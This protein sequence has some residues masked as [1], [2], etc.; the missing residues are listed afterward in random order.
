MKQKCGKKQLILRLGVQVIFAL[1][2]AVLIEAAFNFRSFTQGYDY[3]DLFP[4][5]TADNGQLIISKTFEESRYIKKLLVNGK[6]QKNPYYTVRLTVI[7]E[8]GAEEM[9]ELEDRANSVFDQ[10]FTNIGYD[11]KSMEI[12]FGD[13]NLVQINGVSISNQ[14]LFSKYRII[15][16]A[17]VLLL[18]S[19]ILIERS[20]ILQHLEWLYAIAAVGFG[21]LL[22]WASGPEAITWDEEAHF[23]SVYTATLNTASVRDQAAESNFSRVPITVNTGEERILLER[24]MNTLSE[25]SKMENAIQNMETGVRQ[26]LIYFP[27]SIFM[28]LARCLKLP[29]SLQ[30]AAGRIGNMLICVLMNILAIRLA[31][32]KKVLIT[33]A[34]LLPTL[35]FQSC[36][37]T[38]DGIIFAALTLG[39]V[40]CLN[41][42]QNERWKRKTILSAFGLSLLLFLWACLAKPVYLP[43]ILFLL[44][45]L[46][47]MLSWC[48]AERKKT[49]KTIVIIIGAAGILAVAG[50][51]IWIITG[52]L[53]GNLFVAADLRGG[54]SDVGAQLESI[55]RHPLSF[56]KMLLEEMLTMDNFR[57]FGDPSLNRYLVSNLMFLNLYVFG[58]LKD[59]WSLILLPLLA[60]VFLAEPMERDTAVKKMKSVRIVSLLTFFSSAALIW[61]SMYLFFTPVGSS[62]IEGVQARYFLPLL[63]PFAGLVQNRRICLK[64]SELRYRQIALILT[65]LLT[66]V[67]IYQGAIAERVL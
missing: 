17:L 53:G 10:A 41:M 5:V 35:I 42:R 2:L 30:F 47:N 13:Q 26:R 12:I 66:G 4:Q 6:F 21:I 9:I 54:T 39:T 58:T 16:F 8:F 56:L 22:I 7:N 49:I 18:I 25:N 15:F 44:F 27:M 40:M 38:Y 31:Q 32:K 67:C 65:F 3:E 50:I 61:L 14:I 28:W 1:F 19:L 52:I 45:P 36:M 23:R 24:Y 63:L 60:M 55:L 34:A 62:G 51:A 46:K 29:F 20:F 43:F 48:S 59:A 57:N 33:V 37:L 64:I 11:V